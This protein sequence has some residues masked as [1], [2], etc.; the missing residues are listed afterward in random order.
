MENANLALIKSRR[1]PLPNLPNI[2]LDENHDI[3][4][5]LKKCRGGGSS[6]SLHLNRNVVSNPDN[7]LH[8]GS[9]T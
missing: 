2:P 4:K 9:N 6:C 1:D 3:P 5:Q 8:T 7:G